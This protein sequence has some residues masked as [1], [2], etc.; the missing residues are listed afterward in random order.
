M[1][2]TCLFIGVSF[3]LLNLAVMDAKED[4]TADQDGYIKLY[5]GVWWQNILLCSLNCEMQTIM[6]IFFGT[7]TLVAIAIGLNTP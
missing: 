4:M 2:G 7:D 5:F 3:P 6:I 1:N